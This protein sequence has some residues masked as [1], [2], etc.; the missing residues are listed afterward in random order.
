MIQE[1]IKSKSWILLI[2]ALLFCA[3]GRSDAQQRRGAA[4]ATEKAAAVK[5]VP[6]E[7]SYTVSMS[8]P[9][10]HLLEVEMKISW[11]RAP[12]KTEVKMAVW[13]PGSYLVRE[14][15]RHVQDFVVVD[16]TGNSL[17]W[18]K[19]NKNTW[20]IETNR[21]NQIRI[22]YRVYSNELTVRTNE[23]NYEHAFFTP[24]ALL[25]F[26]NGHLD[27]PSTVTVKPY[28]DWKVATGLKK[29]ADR[30]NSFHADN[31]DILFDSPFEVSDFKEKKFIVRGIPHR[32]VVTGEGNYDLDRIAADTA[33]II[34]EC[35]K[36]FG[37]L[38]L[39]DYTFILN[40]RGRG[41]LEHL[42]STALQFDRFGFESESRYLSF[43]GLVAHEY[44]HLFNVKRIRP[45]PLGPF[46][47]ENENYT[48]LLWV[49]E[50]TTSY[51]EWVLMRRAGLYRAEDV[52]DNAAKIGESLETQ[53][54][55]FQTS[56]EE[57]SFDAWIKAY[58]PDE[59]SIN[60]QIS[61]YSKGELVNFLL[62]IK[63]RTAS[64][65][66]KSLDDVLRLL[67]DEYY[68][69]DKTYTSE[70]FQRICEIMAGTGLD[71][72]FESY[73]R[74]KD[75]LNFNQILRE[76]GL[77]L[78]KSKPENNDAYLG[79][80]FSESN[81]ILKIISIPS[82]TPA[83]KSG[84]NSGDQIVAIDGYRATKSTVNFHISRKKAGDKAVMTVFRHDKL[85]EIDVTLGKTPA[86]GYKI[87]PVSNPTAQQE[88]LFLEYLGEG[89]SKP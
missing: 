88:A 50:G 25:M 16:G 40:L 49:A 70:D 46:D 32:Y 36:I 12:E 69:N 67:Y 8:N 82:G 43:L 47:Y 17:D 28:G 33:K 34:E 89:L 79:A 72:F 45:Y 75:E 64:Q 38:P 10:N 86:S 7:V 3:S 44:F 27:I 61:Y 35:Y 18:Q 42:N 73:V 52:L 55:R 6:R 84:L 51:Y 30:A 60:R 76:M 19:I 13:T 66:A 41:G 26:P 39:Q 9:S 74:G 29:I 5:S 80:N 4:N 15:A 20:Q 63:I 85:R 1:T 37:E 11:A 31:Y 87:V 62:D 71:K 56:L 65:G 81:D 53:P 22:G 48:K 68:K 83:Y 24:A 59:H 77:E 23:L 14:Y 57:A 78:K 54:G 2:A 21:A 58:R